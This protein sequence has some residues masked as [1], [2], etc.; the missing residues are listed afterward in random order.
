MTLE[1]FYI[2]IGGSY[3]NIKT[4]IKEDSSIKKYLNM[5]AKDETYNNLIKA[6]DDSNYKL[7]FQESHTLK[8]LCLTLSLD[9]LL[10]PVSR[11]VE[12]TRNGENKIDPADVELIKATY[13]TIITKLPDIE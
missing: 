12:A 9:K 2:E 13:N 5:F 3:Q 11:I 8:G 4:R 7:I 6:L 1:T 10:D